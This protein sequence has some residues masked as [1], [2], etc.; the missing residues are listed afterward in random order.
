[1]NI[2]TFIKLQEQARI[3]IDLINHR[4]GRDCGV[5]FARCSEIY[6]TNKLCHGGLVGLAYGITITSSYWDTDYGSRRICWRD[7]QDN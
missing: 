4:Y 3:Y 2:E 6:R 7:R 5:G 1:M